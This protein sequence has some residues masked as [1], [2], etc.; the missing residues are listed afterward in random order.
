MNSDTIRDISITEIHVKSIT[1]C[2]STFPG[3]YPVKD[4]DQ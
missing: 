3:I 4:D 2:K 1:R